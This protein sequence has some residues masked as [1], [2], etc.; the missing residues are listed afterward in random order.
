MVESMTSGTP[1]A[2]A[3]AASPSMSAI[4]PDG[5]ATVS[6]KTSLVRSVMAAA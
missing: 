6:A 4:S 3:T 1:A 2:C 5:F